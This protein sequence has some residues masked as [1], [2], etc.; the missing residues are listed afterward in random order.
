VLGKVPYSGYKGPGSDFRAYD[1]PDVAP[2]RTARRDE[3]NYAVLINGKTW[4]VFAR[5]ATAEKAA[6][7]IERKYNKNTEVKATREPVSED[8][9]TNF[10]KRIGYT[11]RGGAAS[12]MMKKQ[13]AQTQQMN[14]DLDPGAAEKG[15]GIGVL[16]VAKARKKASEKGVKAPGSLRASPNTRDPKRLPEEMELNEM[17]QPFV[18]IDTADGNKVVAIASDEKGAKS[19]I[20]SAELPPMRIKDKSTLKIVK[21]R[22]KQHIGMPLKEEVEH[23]IRIGD[24]VQTL[25]MG[26]MQGTVTGF[27]KKGGIDKVMFKHES[28]KVYATVPGNL[29]VID[30]AE[31]ESITESVRNFTGMGIPREYAEAFM[32]KYAVKNEAPL[33]EIDGVPKT[34]DISLGSFIINVL[35]NGD[36]RGFGKTSHTGKTLYS[37]LHMINGKIVRPDRTGDKDEASRGMSKK[38]KFYTL[39]GSYWDLYREPKPDSARD[40]GGDAMT[41]DGAI[42]TYMNDTFMSKMR[43]MMEKMVDDI[44][45]NLRKLDKSKRSYASP[46]DRERALDAISN[47]EDIAERG[48]NRETME[49]F[50]RHLGRYSNMGASIPRNEAELRKVLKDT[51][52]ARAKWAKTVLDVAKRNHERVKN[53]LYKPTM[54]KLTADIHQEDTVKKTERLDDT[55]VEAKKKPVP[56]N[57]D[58][59]SR[60]KA[61]AKQKY[62]V[63]PSA[64]SSAFAAKWYKEKG[65][66]WRMGT[67]EDLEQLEELKC[68]PGYERVPGT[69]AGEPGSCRKKGKKR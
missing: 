53:M 1:E 58:L 8:F 2:R 12:D 18:V 47:I 19:S 16:D 34:R 7:T 14:K 42:Y 44:Y 5:R 29:K 35:P 39:D 48:F 60:A 27:S 57:P 25:K 4:K 33:K 65:G 46:S 36:V 51:P 32:K 15:L 52:N 69:T 28:G 22:K 45:A 9:D 54:D 66:G 40:T 6:A 24:T 43:P 23:D 30:S 17:R 10:S 13:A 31:T 38:G 49:N 41:G 50:L 26:Q 20:A 67:K 59:W 62:D 63:W 61:A 21:T 68:W 11:V 64:Y 55:V 37:M 3:S 56:T